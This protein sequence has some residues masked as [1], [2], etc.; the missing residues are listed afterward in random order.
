MKITLQPTHVGTIPADHAAY[1]VNCHED[2]GT[3]LVLF[4]AVWD[5]AALTAV[6]GTRKLPKDPV[7]TG[8]VEA[9]AEAL[10]SRFLPT[11]EAAPDSV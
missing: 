7:A 4:N 3:E 2:D 6:N 5:G 11:P 1:T 10:A 8:T 9:A